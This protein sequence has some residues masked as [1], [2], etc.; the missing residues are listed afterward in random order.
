MD[1]SYFY[2]FVKDAYVYPDR[3]LKTGE[4]A[5]LSQDI[6]MTLNFEY[7]RDP[8][9]A[10]NIALSYKD[11]TRE[12][13]E[14]V[15]FQ[16]MTDYFRTI[17]ISGV[18]G[19]TFWQGTAGSTGWNKQT[20]RITAIQI[21]PAPGQLSSSGSGLGVYQGSTSSMNG[22]SVQCKCVLLGT[23]PANRTQPVNKTRTEP[24][25]ISNRMPSAR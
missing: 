3:I 11:L 25:L 22:I 15:T 14:F 8:V 16:V 6:W 12:A 2:D 18:V 10:L 9:T 17:D 7:V 24:A 5:N 13:V 23:A 1:Y 21:T 20:A 19:A 4:F